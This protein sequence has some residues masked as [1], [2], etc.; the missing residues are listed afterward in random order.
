MR[1]L[2][3]AAAMV[4]GCRLIRVIRAASPTLGPFRKHIVR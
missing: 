2:T 4:S 1:Y 3:L